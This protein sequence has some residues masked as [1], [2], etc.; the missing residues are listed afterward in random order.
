MGHLALAN[1]L[2][3]SIG[4]AAHLDRPN[5]PVAPAYHPADFVV[6]LAPLTEATLDHSVSLE[7][8][9][10]APVPEG[11]DYRRREPMKRRL[12]RVI[13]PLGRP[14]TKPSANSTPRFVRR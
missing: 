4:G 3:V 2:L 8:P 9:L 5:L 12:R 1:N 11:R 13:W 6:R 14:T 7:R 10:H